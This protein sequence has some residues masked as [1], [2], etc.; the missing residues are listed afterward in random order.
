VTLQCVAGLLPHIGKWE[1]HL[2]LDTKLS[3]Y[4]SINTKDKECGMVGFALANKRRMEVQ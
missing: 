4:L 2:S 1:A 3:V